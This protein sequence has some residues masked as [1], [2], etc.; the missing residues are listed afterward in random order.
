MEKYSTGVTTP[1]MAEENVPESVV[2]PKVEE[3]SALTTS[4]SASPSLQARLTSSSITHHHLL[5]SN[6]QEA[7]I[8]IKDEGGD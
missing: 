2:K 4:S 3:T 7:V 5:Q 6:L 1:I 8:T